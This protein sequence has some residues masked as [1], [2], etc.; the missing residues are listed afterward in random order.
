VLFEKVS[1]TEVLT[2]NVLQNGN[3]QFHNQLLLF[4]L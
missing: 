4:N 2:K 1:I 3:S